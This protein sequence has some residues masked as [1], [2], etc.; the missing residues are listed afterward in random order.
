MEKCC[1]TTPEKPDTKGHQHNHSE[2]DGHDH[3]GHDHSHDSGDQTI[4][5]MFLPALYPLLFCY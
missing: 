3:D 2:G 5:Q 4:F 1:S